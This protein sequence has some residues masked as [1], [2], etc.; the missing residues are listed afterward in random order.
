M[1]RILDHA[2]AML[3]RD[4]VQAVHVHRQ[5]GE[6]HRHDRP[7][8]GS[9]GRLGRVEVDVARVGLYIDEHRTGADTHDHVSRRDEAHRRRDDLVARAD[10]AGLQ[11][12]LERS[13]C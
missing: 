1:G 2:Q 5:P 3:S 13:S 6:M 8:A 12:D 7:G 11:G 10:A 4:R 9:D